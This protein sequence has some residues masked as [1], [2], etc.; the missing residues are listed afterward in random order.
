MIL[1]SKFN[2][3]KNIN[4]KYLIIQTRHESAWRRRCVKLMRDCSWGCGCFPTLR[5]HKRRIIQTNWGSN[6]WNKKYH[7][8][9]RISHYRHI[10]KYQINGLRIK[11]IHTLMMLILRKVKKRC[12]VP[13]R[14]T[15]AGWLLGRRTTSPLWQQTSF[16][17]PKLCSS[18]LE[19]DLLCFANTKKLVSVSY[20]IY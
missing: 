10:Q 1:F 18:V 11:K 20:A 13:W 5:R 8:I 19:P 12:C 2:W 4:C 7:T 17:P 16:I 6:N 3:V 9:E 14:Q 15:D